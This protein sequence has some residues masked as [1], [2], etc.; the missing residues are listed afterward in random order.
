MNKSTMQGTSTASAT[1]WIVTADS[2]E[3]LDE[4]RQLLELDGVNGLQYAFLPVCARSLTQVY[5]CYTEEVATLIRNL[6]VRL[7]HDGTGILS[8]DGSTEAI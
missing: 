5:T 1:S 3:A 8:I 7:K 6:A 4:L 2:I